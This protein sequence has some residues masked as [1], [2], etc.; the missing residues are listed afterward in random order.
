MAWSR[1]QEQ[2]WWEG[3]GFWTWCEGKAKR[4]AG[5]LHVREGGDPGVWAQHQERQ[6]CHRLT[7]AD[8]RRSG[9]QG[10]CKL[11]FGHILEMPLKPQVGS[12]TCESGVRGVVMGRDIILGV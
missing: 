11:R 7:W 10:D 6:S 12:W 3:T 5:G 4:F 8:C 9:C 1:G 2:R